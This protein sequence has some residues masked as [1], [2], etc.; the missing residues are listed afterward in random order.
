[1][2]AT[3]YEFDELSDEAKERARDWYRGVIEVEDYAEYVIEDAAQCAELMGITID[4]REVKLMGGKTRQEPVVYWSGFSSQ[5]DG[6]CFEGRWA[7]YNVKPGKLK[8]HAPQD[9]KL[10]KIAEVFE[11]IARAYPSAGFSVRHSGHYYHKHSTTFDCE[12]GEPTDELTAAVVAALLGHHL[13]RSDN[14]VEEELIEA[15]RD[16]MQWIYD[17]LEA[18]YEYQSSD[19]QVDE[20][21]R[22]NEYTFTEDGDRS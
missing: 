8:E 20:T 14:F 5:G 18:E 12:A 19:E 3:E 6:A 13:N 9:E 17:R 15:A 10:H 11:H 16:F 7:A 21:I 4:T 1:M 2:T 22:A